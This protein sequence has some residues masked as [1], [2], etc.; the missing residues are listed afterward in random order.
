MAP[1]SF[2][3]RKVP[4]INVRVVIYRFPFPEMALAG[5]RRATHLCILR[6]A[7]KTDTSTLLMDV[8]ASRIH[9]DYGTNAL[10][11]TPIRGHESSAGPAD[12][13]RRAYPWPLMGA[14][15]DIALLRRKSAA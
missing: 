15:V 7:P 2:G 12:I 10:D 4:L 8:I 3:T 13:P 1:S 9:V 6:T 5:S 14:H 11:R